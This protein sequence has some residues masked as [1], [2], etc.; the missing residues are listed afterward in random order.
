MYLLTLHQRYSRR[1]MAALAGL[2]A[3][4]AFAYVALLLGAVAH[5]AH[6]TEAES[7]LGT[8]SAE[9]SALEG[10]YL[11]QTQA[12][13]PEAAARMGFVAPT[14]VA[15]IFASTQTLTLRK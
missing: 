14:D 8:L 2:V 1:L 6:R 4:C 10:R 15:T 13:S 5:A 9:V 12:L 11:S 3:L 7:K